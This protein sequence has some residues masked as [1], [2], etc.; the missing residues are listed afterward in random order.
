MAITGG[1]TAAKCRRQC[2][3]NR[4]GEN[5]AT[6]K[7]FLSSELDKADD[8]ITSLL[9]EVH[10]LG[11][12]LRGTKLLFLPHLPSAKFSSY[13]IP[14]KTFHP[15]NVER[16]HIQRHFPNGHLFNIR[17]VHLDPVCLL[18]NN[19]FWKINSRKIN[20][21]FMFG[22]V[23]KNKLENIFRCLVMS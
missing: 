3:A 23:M 8:T 20:Y 1:E 16:C 13:G 18:K 9:L 2:G 11:R 5:N 15:K 22:N 17:R 4:C 19:Y 7:H 14:K 10:R 12:P 6:W 21:F